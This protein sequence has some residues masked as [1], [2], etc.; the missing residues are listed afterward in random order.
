[1]ARA[2]LV[3]AILL[4]GLNLPGQLASFL[5]SLP[6][7]RLWA[8]PDE[9]YRL[10]LGEVPYDLLRAADAILPRDAPVLLIT[11]GRDVRHLDYTT[12]HRALYFLSPRTVWW[13]AP[14]PPDG[15]WESRWWISAPLTPESIRSVAAEKEV[16]CLLVTDP[17]LAIVAGQIV[18]SWEAGYL[19]QV[20]ETTVCNSPAAAQPI[21]RAYAGPL[22]PVQI[23]FAIA[24]IGL[25]GNGVLEAVGLIGHR[26]RGTEAAALA[27]AF[28][29]GLLSV[30][31][32]WLNALG[33]SLRGQL[34]VLTILP[35][36]VAILS[37]ILIRSNLGGASEIE[38]ETPFHVQFRKPIFPVSSALLAFLVLQIALVTVS[39]LGRPLYIWDSWVNWGMKARTIFLED[40]ISPAVYAD[41]SRAVTLQDY[42]LL[43]PLAEAWIYGWLGAPDDRFAGVPSIL[44]YL[45]LAGVCYS[46]LRR[47]GV[48][49][50]FALLPTVAL[51]SITHV[52]GSAG[53]VFPDLPLAAF[54]TIG[55]V[56]LI[57]WLEGGAPGLLALAALGAGLMPWTKRE[58]L[59]LLFALS[60]STLIIRRGDRRAWLGV[61]TLV[62]A[63]ALLA[64]PWWAFVAWNNISN[65][66]FL[67]LTVTTLLSNS[68]RLP[69]IAWGFL[70]NLSSPTWNFVWPMAALL[71]TVGAVSH[72]RSQSRGSRSRRTHARI[73][74]SNRS[75]RTTNVVVTAAGPTTGLATTMSTGHLLLATPIICLCLMA[76]GYV[77]SAYVPYQQHIASSVNRLAVHVAPMVVL[78]I[79]YHR[80][81]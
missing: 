5:N 22:W 28:G 41:P 31:M 36:G 16:A 55:A 20:R 68:G 65:D 78:W 40:H 19:L 58:G 14:A 11:P 67:P 7:V 59:V 79:A 3:M 50:T 23:L 63:A 29:V 21:S 12:F 48:S 44:L 56:Y 26:V 49:R 27:G 15:T 45:A 76:F 18:A 38:R 39:A 77:F 4:A 47:R 72:W 42:P 64:G 51:V 37:L 54:A 2:I 71:A 6:V 73:A 61:W 74:D 57:E 8:E 62:L 60:L 75:A 46:A 1:M 66:A 53:L 24:L 35:A 10:Q 52:A 30:L 81:S 33:A 80:Q 13:L 43:M 25:I 34:I 17:S 70:S 32:L 69:V 9:Q